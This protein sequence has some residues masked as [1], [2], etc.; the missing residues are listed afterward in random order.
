[1]MMTK[2]SLKEEIVDEFIKKAGFKSRQAV[3]NYISNIKTKECPHA[4]QNAAAQVAAQ[5]KRFSIA[6]KLSKEDKHTLPHNISEIVE[7]YIPKNKKVVT[8]MAKSSQP[9]VKKIKTNFGA[10][11]LNEAQENA[12]IYPYVY[13]LE[14]SLRKLILETFKDQSN[15]WDNSRIVHK[16]IKKYSEIIQEAEKKHRWLDKRGSH[17]IYYVNL[18]NLFKI[19]EMNWNPH[20]KPI[21][22]DLGHLRTWIAESVPIRNL[23]AHNINTHKSERD[24]IRIRSQYICKLIENKN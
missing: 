9:H 18:E 12:N 13:I 1:M 24:N 11:F 3:K 5:I 17:P 2:I 19:I 7:R 6:K 23:V 20:F 8:N 15:W 4:T 16:D 22:N 21:F 14:N 10:D